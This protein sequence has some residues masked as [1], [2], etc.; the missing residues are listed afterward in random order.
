[1]GYNLLCKWGINW[2]YNPLTLTLYQHFQQDIHLYSPEL[3]LIML[4]SWL[5]FEIPKATSPWKIYPAN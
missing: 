1:M 5:N 3:T 4:L 2:G